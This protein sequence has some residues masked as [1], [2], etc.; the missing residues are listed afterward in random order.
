MSIVQPTLT[1]DQKN[2]IINYV[3]MYR[4][5]HQ[6]PPMVWDETIAQFSQYWSYYLVSNNLFQ[7]SK[8]QLYGENLAWFKGYG[9]DVM[10]LI[11]KSIDNWYNEV[12]LYD[13]NN[14]VF[15]SETGHFT[16]L[17]W[18]AST[19]FA[20]GI[21]LDNNSNTVDVTMNTSPPGNVSG[22][23]KNNVLP[24]VPLP[25]PVPAPAPI[26]VP[27]PVP[28]P[29]ND[30]LNIIN[31]LNNVI[32]LLNSNAPKYTT[33]NI[34]YKIVTE[35]NNIIYALNSTNASGNAKL[36][37]DL[38]III[39]DLYSIITNI[40]RRQSKLIIIAN[41]NNIMNKLNTLTF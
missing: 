8:T 25:A 33:F 24:L 32:N 12:S 21:S 5:K 29:V 41:V 37:T 23:F 35:I 11:K 26:P 7:H 13:F 3:N 14:P 18:K 2:E 17:V 28:S 9:T 31:H 22:Q 4:K 19:K 34:I 39:N 40:Q 10:M 30:K 15:S 27:A 16:C 36:V 6:A 20:I 38:Y 1:S